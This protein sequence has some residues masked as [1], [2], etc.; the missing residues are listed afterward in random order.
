[1]LSMHQH[2]AMISWLCSISEQE[3]R[4]L[5]GKKHK[6][7]HKQ[8]AIIWSALRTPLE[9]EKEREREMELCLLSAEHLPFT[10]GLLFGSC[11]A[12]DACSGRSS[13]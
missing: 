8:A 7:F 9:R 1:M 2:M 4:I 12:W 5:D 11:S 10:Q 3:S 13:N 6:S